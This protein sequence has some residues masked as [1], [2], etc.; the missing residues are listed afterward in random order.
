MIGAK[1]KTSRVWL[2]NVGEIPRSVRHM[3]ARDADISRV[4]PVTPALKNASSRL[5]GT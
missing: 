5:G 4:A 1:F 3:K 2:V